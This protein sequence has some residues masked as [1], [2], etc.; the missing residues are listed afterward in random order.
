MTTKNKTEKAKPKKGK[1]TKASKPSQTPV[2]K[3]QKKASQKAG[4]VSKRLQ[5][6]LDNVNAQKSERVTLTAKDKS[7]LSKNASTHKRSEIAIR[8]K[9][10][11]KVV[12]FAKRK[13]NKGTRGAIYM[14][15]TLVNKGLL[16]PSL[17]TR[18]DWEDGFVKV[19]KFPDASKQLLAYQ[20]FIHHFYQA[21]TSSP[22]FAKVDLFSNNSEVYETKAGKRRYRQLTRNQGSL[23]L[24]HPDHETWVLALK[25]TKKKTIAPICKAFAQHCKTVKTKEQKF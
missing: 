22:D 3:K 16:S 19:F 5:A 2:S 24:T 9:Q 17:F 6:L 12:D 1:A 25:E 8:G 11:G 15:A 4:K 20:T 7:D 23:S 21:Y 10:K 13:F 14:I 18:T